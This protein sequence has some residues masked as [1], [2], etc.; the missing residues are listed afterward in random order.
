MNRCIS[1]CFDSV[2]RLRRSN[3]KPSETDQVMAPEQKERKK[4]RRET[5]T[6][7]FGK[8]TFS[9][10]TSLSESFTVHHMLTLYK[11]IPGLH[12]PWKKEF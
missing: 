12:D 3:D 2:E 4:R 9:S 5:S 7:Q 11:T 8:C 1:F 10:A 6:E